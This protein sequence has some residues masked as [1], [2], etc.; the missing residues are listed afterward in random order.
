MNYYKV[1]GIEE[2]ATQ[3]EIKEAYNRQVQTFKEEV[4][5]EKRLEKFLDL[6]KEAYDALNYEESIVQN[7]MEE[8]FDEEVSAL[9]KKNK[10]EEKPVDISLNKDEVKVANQNIENSYAATVLMSREEILKESLIQHHEPEEERI[11]FKSKEDFEECDVFFDDDEEED[12]E[13]KIIKK[14]KQK[15]PYKKNK[16]SSSVKRNSINKNNKEYNSRDRDNIA[17]NEYKE[18]N[19]KVVVKKEKNSGLLLI[20]LK[21]LVLPVIAILSILIFICKI[22]SISSWLVSKVIIVG[23]IAIAAIHGYRIYIGQVASEYNIFVACGI[24]FIVSIFLPSIV[25]ILPNTL[26]GI[27]NSL[28]DFV[29]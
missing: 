21:I 15:N 16:N 13:E 25:R 17:N 12:F 11:I 6:F 4:K 1:L 14:I 19:K 3:E 9:F 2:N 8:I 7:Q 29:F 5:D 10:I 28:K 22:I 26:Q 20:P 24:G 23:A 18:K 27:N